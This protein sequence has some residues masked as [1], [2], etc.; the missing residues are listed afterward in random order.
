MDYRDFLR[1]H[2]ASRAEATIAMVD[3][4]PEFSREV[5]I[6]DVDDS[7]RVVGFEEKPHCQAQLE[8][9][10]NDFTQHGRLHLQSRVAVAGELLISRTI[11]FPTLA[12][13]VK[14]ARMATRIG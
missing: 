3:Y 9:R 12:T 8:E 6:L 13:R 10:G 11:L 2:V 1:F 4:P 5:E 7:N 14:C